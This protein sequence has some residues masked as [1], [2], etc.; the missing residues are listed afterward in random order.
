MRIA[1]ALTATLGALVLA[2]AAGG[3]PD[4]KKPPGKNTPAKKGAAKDTV[5]AGTVTG[6]VA[7]EL[8]VPQGTSC[9]AS[10]A[11]VQRRVRVRRD[12]TLTA[13]GAFRAGRGIDV[14]RGATLQVI[15]TQIGIAGNVHANG[16]KKV[17]LIREA[18]AGSSGVVGGSV[19]LLRTGDVSVLSLTIGGGVQVHGGGGE[20]VELG[21]NRI[22]LSLD[23][24]RARMLHP[25][26]PRVFSIHS[27]I[28]GRHVRVLDNHA[29]GAISPLFIGGNRL[30]RGNLTCRRNVPA[31][32][33][34]GPGGTDRNVVRH[35]AKRGQCAS[36]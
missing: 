25:Q 28:V 11:V 13:R 29:T 16:A 8:V 22:F 5:C 15:G 6:V 35:G 30:L 32:V 2:S 24:T 31:P 21:A 12:A 17:A 26:R 19:T 14:A 3:M 34:S 7:G 20:G 18:R 36:L 27:N 1:L 33:N 9:N 10:G 23:V 4:A